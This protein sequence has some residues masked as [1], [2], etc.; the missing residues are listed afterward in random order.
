MSPRVSLVA[1]PE[2]G[3]RALLALRRHVLLVDQLQVDHLRG[4][5]GAMLGTERPIVLT[6]EGDGSWAASK[7]SPLMRPQNGMRG[8]KVGVYGMGEIGRKIAMGSLDF[9]TVLADVAAAGAA[10]REAG[11]VGVV[12]YCWGGLLVWRSAET[13]RGLSAAVA[14]LFGA[15]AMQAVGRAPGA[16]V[17]RPLHPQPVAQ[18]GIDY[19]LG[20]T[21]GELVGR[22]VFDLYRDAPEIAACAR[23]AV[24]GD[25]IGRASASIRRR[26]SSTSCRDV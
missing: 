15:F 4:V 8:R 7:P 20:V 22:S 5:A 23:R 2:A 26:Y 16:V 25:H 17:D 3:R 11:K 10:A 24:A 6:I 21:P 14:Y 19:L 1:I 18:A 13:V 9:Q 12:G